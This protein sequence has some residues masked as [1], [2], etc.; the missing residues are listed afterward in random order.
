[1]AKI[2]EKKNEGFLWD[3]VD[4]GKKEHRIKWDFVAKPKEMG[5]MGIG[6]LLIMK[7]KAFTC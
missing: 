5:G 7:N 1:M 6:N 4:D 2:M 3:G